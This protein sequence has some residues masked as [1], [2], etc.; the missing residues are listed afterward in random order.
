MFCWEGASRFIRRLGGRAGF[1]PG[2]GY[3]YCSGGCRHG[4]VSCEQEDE[5]VRSGSNLAV[6]YFVRVR[7]VIYKKIDF[8]RFNVQKKSLVDYNRLQCI[9]VDF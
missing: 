9:L 1:V 5:R 7:V 6:F 3:C 4:I 8:H 2:V